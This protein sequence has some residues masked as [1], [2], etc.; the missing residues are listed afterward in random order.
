MV[1]KEDEGENLRELRKFK[2]KHL[3]RVNSET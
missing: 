3:Q 2:V 1:D